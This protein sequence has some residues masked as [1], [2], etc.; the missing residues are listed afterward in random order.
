MLGDLGLSE[1]DYAPQF[2]TVEVLAPVAERRRVRMNPEGVSLAE[3][4]ASLVKR[5][6][7]DGVL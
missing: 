2:A 6:A 7:A 1:A 4:A 3:A 5:L